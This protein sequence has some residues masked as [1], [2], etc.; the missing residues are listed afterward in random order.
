MKSLIYGLASASL[1]LTSTTAFA[2]PTRL[3]A[4][5]LDQ[6]SAGIPPSGL[7][8]PFP[9]APKLPLPLPLPAAPKLPLPL[10]FPAAPKLPLPILP[11]VI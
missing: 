3:S 8:L 10:P 11:P 7:P 5:Q 2:Q 4:T 1:L 9:V 6:V